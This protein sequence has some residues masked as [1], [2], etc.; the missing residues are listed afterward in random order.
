MRNWIL[1][2]AD[3]PRWPVRSW[4]PMRPEVLDLARRR[5]IRPPEYDCRRPMPTPGDQ[6]TGASPR[7]SPV[8]GGPTSRSGS[9]PDFFGGLHRRLGAGS[10]VVLCDNRYVEG[11]STP[12]ARID[13]AGNSYQRR[14]LE[15]GDALEVLKNFP[16]GDALSRAIARTE[17]SA[18]TQ[19][20]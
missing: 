14:R 8:S 1:D 5:A 7:R 2:G 19:S 17:P 6:S 10:R 15:S 9:V 3:S 12:M 4:Q 18:S 20:S 16:S 13:A 11:S